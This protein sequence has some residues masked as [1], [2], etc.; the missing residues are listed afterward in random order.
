M[1]AALFDAFGAPLR[2]ETVPDPEPPP[3]GVVIQ[4][5]A[6]GICRSDWHGWQGH[7]ADIKTLPHIP[8]HE[9]AGEVVAVGVEVKRWTIGDRVTVPFCLGCGRCPQCV[10]GNHQV[11]DDYYQPGFTGWGTFAEYVALPYADVNL[12]RIPEALDDVAVASLGCRFTTAFRAVVSQAGLRGGE[13]IVI[14]GCGGVGLSAVMVAAALGA[15]VIAVDIND[16][17]LD[18]ARKIGAAH[19]INAQNVSDVVAAVRELT[20]GGAHV[21]VD[22]LGSAATARNGILSLRKRGR[23]VQIGLLVGDDTD[24]ALPM[25]P[26][27]ANELVILGSHGM[28]AHA[29]DALL[30]MIEAGQLNPAQLVTERVTLEEAPAVLQRMTDFGVTGVTVIDRF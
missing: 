26:V 13:W 8:G 11:C 18:L 4:L 10:S 12:V 5:R 9:L 23:H 20:Q 17:T 25:G 1:K 3:D 22:A 16:A 24:P 6:N 15:A 29:Y 2:I 19:T 27:I 7:D 14:Y 28:Q 30:R 21:A